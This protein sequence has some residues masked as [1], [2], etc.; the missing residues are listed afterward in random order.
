M[1]EGY[2]VDREKMLKFIERYDTTISDS[3]MA[4]VPYNRT[5]DD[6]DR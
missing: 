5:V 3:R 4:R 2:N 1:G 6:N